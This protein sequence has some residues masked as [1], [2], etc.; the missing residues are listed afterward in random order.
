MND[1]TKVPNSARI[2]IDVEMNHHA[3]RQDE[4][5]TVLLLDERGKAS[6]RDLLETL[7]PNS[8]EERLERIKAESQAQALIQDMIETDPQAVEHLSLLWQQNIKPQLEAAN[9]QLSKAS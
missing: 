8:W 7:Y 5:N 9:K 4:I 3:K 2:K 6:L 1:L